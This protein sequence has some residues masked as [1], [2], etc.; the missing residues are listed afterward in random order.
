MKQTFFNFLFILLCIANNSSQLIAMEQQE[1]E[2]IF[3]LV[4]GMIRDIGKEGSQAVAKNLH[5]FR[6]LN[7]MLL[8][9]MQL[10]KNG[11][12]QNLEEETFTLQIISN[13][14]IKEIEKNPYNLNIYTAVDNILGSVTS[15]VGDLERQSIQEPVIMNYLEKY[16]AMLGRLTSETRDIRQISHY[17]PRSN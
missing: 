17:L 13:V 9:E 5:N 10:T 12:P 11:M 14:I 16:H 3:S 15:F 4:V 1:P 2:N 8:S 6:S 7:E